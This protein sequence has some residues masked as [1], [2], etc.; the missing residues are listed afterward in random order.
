MNIEYLN[1]INRLK[2]NH[3]YSYP[4]NELV[5]MYKYMN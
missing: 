5:C 2:S 4:L 3:I 1:K